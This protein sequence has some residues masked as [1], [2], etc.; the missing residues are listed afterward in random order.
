M[1]V[2]VDD[3]PLAAE[4]LGLSTVGEVL[5]HLQ[6]DNRLVTSLL[7][8]GRQPD[9]NHIGFVRQSTLAGH[10]VY[11]ET[12]E[13]REMAIEVLAA[14]E[15]QLS[16]NDAFRNEAIEQLQRNQPNKALEKLGGCFAIWQAAQEAVVKVSQLLRLDLEQIRVHG[17]PLQ[18]LLSE[19]ATQ[20]RSIKT[21]LESRDFV[22]LSD[23][24]T[25]EAT[26]TSRDWRDALRALRNAIA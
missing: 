2:T 11:I 7:I 26:E 25:Y 13:P 22:T 9:L 16:Q 19:F 21:A 23:I 12:A 20:L 15:Q 14:V 4:E 8:D 5:A 10:T 1:S 24:L 6:R 18:T 3:S 17:R